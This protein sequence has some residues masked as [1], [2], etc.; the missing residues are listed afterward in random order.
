[1]CFRRMPSNC[2]GSAAIAA[3]R[4]LVAGVGLELDPDAAERLEGVRQHQQLRLDV[5]A[6]AP[7]R[8]VEPGPADLDDAVEGAHIE[9]ASAADDRAACAWSGWRRPPRCRCGVAASEASNQRVEVLAAAAY[10]RQPAPDLRRLGRLP[11]ILRVRLFE[12]LEDHQL[13]LE[14]DGQVLH[15]A[16]L[17]DSPLRTSSAA[18]SGASREPQPSLNP[19]RRFRRLDVVTH[20]VVPARRA[21]PRAA[22]GQG[23]RVVS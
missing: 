3:S 11:E 4:A 12:R 5:D 23:S 19:S 13:A 10:V 22:C 20:H 14:P 17:T 21:E 7:G 8:R 18:A 16:I 15:R 6:A 2:A 1:M 9:E